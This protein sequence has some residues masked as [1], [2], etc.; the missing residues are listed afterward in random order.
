MLQALHKHWRMEGPAPADQGARGMGRWIYLCL[1]SR[2][3][4]SERGMPLGLEEH[5]LRFSLQFSSVT[6]SSGN[7]LCGL[8]SGAIVGDSV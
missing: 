3:R 2:A 7:G 6:R 5:K 8:G 1:P 4:A